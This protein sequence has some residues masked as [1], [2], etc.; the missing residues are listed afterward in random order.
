MKTA[1]QIFALA[2]EKAIAAKALLEA[3]T[4]DVPKALAM[5][6]E[7]EELEKQAKA[8]KAAEAKIKALS[9]PDRNLSL[10]TGED[11]N[12]P[13]AAP[14]ED[15][16]I[17]A[18][19]ALRYGDENDATS[20][21]L[22]DL[23]GPDY[24]VKR[25]RQAQVFNRW[26]RTPW[27]QSVPPEGRAFLW[28]P[29]SIKRALEEGM[30][31]AAM[32][33]VMVEAQDTLGGY[34]VPEDWRMTLIERL[35]GMTVVRPR[36]TVLTTSRDAVEIPTSTGGDSQ[37][38]SAVRVTWVE[39]TPTAGT[40]ATNPTFGLE[41]IPVHTVMA[42]TFLSRNLVEDA[43]FNLAGWL[44]Q[45]FSEAS[46]I[47]EDNKFLTGIGA[48]VPQGILPNGANGLGLTYD[49]SGD[50]DELTWDGLIAVTYG[51]DAQYRQNAVWIGEKATYEA[52]A[53]L[54]DGDGNYLWRYGRDNVSGQPLT[55]QGYPVLEQ[56]VMPT[57]GAGTFPLLFGDL[58]GYY[59]VDRIGMSVERYLD[60]STARINQVCYVMRRRL[61][62]Q[63]GESWRFGLQKVAAS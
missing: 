62:G 15:P 27:D 34:I 47:D 42:E 59:I 2:K 35:P 13:P 21:I 32:K 45:K 1:E 55:L 9:E 12:D 37:Y 19:Y 54:K 61:G 56:E 26:L 50:A 40:A 16:A 24:A 39:E 18:A 29:K 17:K 5:L 11:K 60:S 49:I 44:S 30:D 22:R 20:Q 25:I 28:T 10:P 6:A 36:A 63:V 57:I 14:K 51:I 52:I 8:M 48:G 23:H 4:P 31:V 53:K 41:K 38:S 33:T 7:S 58:R 43:A 46:A 3:E